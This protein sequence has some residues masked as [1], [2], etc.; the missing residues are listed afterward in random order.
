[1]VFLDPDASAARAAPLIV[2]PRSGDISLA[3]C[4]SAGKKRRSPPNPSSRGAAT[5]W[6]VAGEPGV[7]APRLDVLGSLVPQR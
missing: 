3:R 2:E 6:L 5:P 4:V 7:A 1:M